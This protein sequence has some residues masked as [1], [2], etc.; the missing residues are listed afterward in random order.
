MNG[1]AEAHGHEEL[2]R[3]DRSVSDHVVY[4]MCRS[5]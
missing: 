3:W 5:L 2:W 1:M 4:R